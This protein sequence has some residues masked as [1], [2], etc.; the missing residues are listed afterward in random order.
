MILI[1]LLGFL[2]TVNSAHASQPLQITADKKVFTEKAV[3]EKGENET[4]DDLFESAMNILRAY[5]TRDRSSNSSYPTL[6]CL[7]MQASFSHRKDIVI[8]HSKFHRYGQ[9][10][11]PQHCVLC[12]KKDPTQRFEHCV[13]ALTE[14]RAKLAQ[15][16]QLSEMRDDKTNPSC[17]HLFPRELVASLCNFVRGFDYDPKDYAPE[18][19]P[20][21]TLLYCFKGVPVASRNSYVCKKTDRILLP[22]GIIRDVYEPQ[23]VTPG[24][25]VITTDNK[26]PIALASY[27]D[28]GWPHCASYIDCAWSHEV[29]AHTPDQRP[30]LRIRIVDSYSDLMF[31]VRE[32]GLA[33]LREKY[34]SPLL[35]FLERKAQ[36][37]ACHGILIAHDQQ[38]PDNPA[39]Q[40]FAKQGYKTNEIIV[41]PEQSE[42]MSP[43]NYKVLPKIQP[44]Q[45]TP[46]PRHTSPS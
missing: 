44:Q 39:K 20:N 27:A 16:A 34:F 38:N 12:G 31:D 33:E 6:S 19:G 14:L 29:L 4:G 36:A 41:F 22:D 26:Y 30:P 21:N 1:F 46:A 45:I 17:I 37:N 40:W 10:E 24:I 2:T 5:G 3:T 43:E 11:Q 7:F 28:Y 15:C 13:F 9:E 25:V 18:P 8:D 42:M 23:V 32:E 35:R